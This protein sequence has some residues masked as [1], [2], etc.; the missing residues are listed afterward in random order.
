MDTMGALEMLVRSAELGSFSAA[1]RQLG[2]T[3][4]AV[5]KQVARLERTLG[6][7]LV[8]RSTRRIALTEEG[9]RLVSAAAPALGQVQAA[10]AQAQSVEASFRGTLRVSLAPG[11]GR[12]YVLPAL[13]PWLAQH[14]Q[15]RFDG[16][17]ENRAVDLVAEGF[18]AGVSGGVELAGRLVARDLAPLH[19]V[20]VASEAY[21]ARHGRPETPEALGRHV[22]LALRSPATGR[23]RAWRLR[24]DR[25]VGIEPEPHHLFDDPEALAV[26]ALEGWGI[27]L[28]GLHH[29]LGW[30]EQ[31]RLVR[32]L[33]DW[34]SDAGAIRVYHPHARRVPP[35][36]RGFVDALVRAARVQR[37]SERL[38]ARRVGPSAQWSP[39]RITPSAR[40]G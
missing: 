12:R 16:R 10:L 34:W 15:L 8:A 3:P 5:S 20:L 7:S 24:G 2:V 11:F 38:D 26:A 35:R 39:S 9:H 32:V 22:L 21:L 40:V 4:A 37:W 30:I 14:S 29:V 27:A 18:D 23:P 19:L 33:P 1:A 13:G 17:F 25:E 36:T 28:A 31:R 6:R